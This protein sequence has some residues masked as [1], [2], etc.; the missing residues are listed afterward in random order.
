MKKDFTYHIVCS[1]LREGISAVLHKFGT[2]LARLQPCLDVP[3]EWVERIPQLFIAR[4][5]P[6][7][8]CTLP[9]GVFT[10][11]VKDRQFALFRQESRVIK[12]KVERP[13]L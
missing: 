8:L 10:E 2:W 1:T 6:S 9:F 5:A 7:I 11:K 3:L 13:P 12:F 4:T